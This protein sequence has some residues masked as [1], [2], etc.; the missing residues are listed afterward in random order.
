MVEIITRQNLP[1][2]EAFYELLGKY[3]FFLKPEGS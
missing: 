3:G 2:F 1:D